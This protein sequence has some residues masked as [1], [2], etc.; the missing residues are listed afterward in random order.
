MTKAE[1]RTQFLAILNRS[2]CTNALADTFIEQGVQRS[3]RLLSL[4][5]QERVDTVTVGAVFTGIDIPA[6]FIKPIAIY[7]DDYKL[8]RVSL[9]QYLETP[10]GSGDPLIW[11]RDQAQFLLKPTPSEGD[12]LSVLYYGEFE[13]F[14]T[15]ATETT[16]SAIA[17][18]LF[19]YGGLV[20]AGDY[21]L[22]DRKSLWEDTYMKTIAELQSQSDDEELAGG[23]VVEPAYIY[24]SQEY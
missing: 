8:R 13:T 11:T 2:D 3:Q 12:V 14:T 15:D 5:T 20:Y 4:I 9:A 24:P 10:T 16:L 7:R 23:A 21:F 19:Y 22:D 1:M 6:D 17:P 18:Q